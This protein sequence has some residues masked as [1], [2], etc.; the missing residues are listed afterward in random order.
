[1]S[2]LRICPLQHLPLPSSLCVHQK[3]SSFFLPRWVYLW[4]SFGCGLFSFQSDAMLFKVT[5]KWSRGTC[6]SIPLSVKVLFFY[7]SVNFIILVVLKPSSQPNF[8]SKRTAHPSTHNMSPLV[9]IS[10]S[11]SVSQ[12]LFC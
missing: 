9:T 5:H 4:K 11:K 10:F 6:T 12:F 8:P 7:N 2:I 1:M 3:I